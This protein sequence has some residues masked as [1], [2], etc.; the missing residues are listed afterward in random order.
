MTNMEKLILVRHGQTEKNIA[1]VVHE[2]GDVE[3]LT[4]TGTV[5]IDKTAERLKEF[6]PNKVYSSKERRAIQSG[7]LIA[8]KLDISYEAI[9]GMEERNWG[10]LSG[11][12]WA[13]IQAILEPMTLEE[14]YTYI[15][16]G[17]ESWEQFERRLISTVSELMEKNKGDSIV[18]VSHGGAI[19][20]LM[21][22]LL[23]APKEESFK[24]NP[25]NASITIFSSDD[26]KLN[27][28]SANDTSH[29]SE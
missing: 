23:G 19:R 16:P 12:T 6:Q 18:V 15:P 27:Q 21:P 8:S 22:Y 20:A 7:E 24:H 1:G 17:G 10:E 5:Q 29:L 28:I 14:R 25:D 13:E 9:D 26:G 2:S 4:S 11:K 3:E